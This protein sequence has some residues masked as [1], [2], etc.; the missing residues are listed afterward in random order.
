M[1]KLLATSVIAAMASL[2]ATA[3]E[4]SFNFV[5]GGYS[6][7]EDADGF[8]IRGNAELNKNFFVRGSYEGLSDDFSVLGGPDDTD[9]NTLTLGLGY[10]HALNNNTSL[11]SHFSYLDFEV[12]SGDAKVTDDGYQLGFGVRNQLSSVTQVYG[13]VTHNS[14]DG[15]SFT[16]L[17]LGLRQ[18]LAENFGAYVEAKADDF[19]G[20]GFGVGVS[21]NF[22]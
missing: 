16:G 20:D 4:P 9:F 2:S 11:Y 7:Y 13:E 21:Y 6:E 18:R 12:K 1:K 22:K 3:N 19:D 10:K 15:N 8:M 17:T 14:I 5:E